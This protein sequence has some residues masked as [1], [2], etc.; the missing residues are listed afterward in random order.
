MSKRDI[1]V[2]AGP[3]ATGKSDL[4]VEVALSLD[5][6]VVSADSRQVYKELDL[7]SGKIAKAEMRG[8]P[9]HMLDVVSLKKN[10]SVYDYKKEAEKVIR[11]IYS[12]GK[13]PIITG[14]TGQYIDALVSDSTIPRVPEN[15]EL[16]N[17]L[18]KQTIQDLSAQLL[19]QNESLQTIVRSKNKRRIIRAL[20]IISTLGYYPKNNVSFSINDL[21]NLSGYYLDFEKE[22]L[23][24]RINDRLK[25]RLRE[26]MIEEV[27][28]IR[29][30]GISDE[31]LI[32][33]GLECRFITFYLRDEIALDEMKKQI[34]TKSWQYA[35]RQRTWFKKYR[36]IL[37]ER[38]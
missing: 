13:V 12:R 33:L 2:I 17:L 6:E 4:A 28:N 19:E 38:L 25:K 7:T 9:H 5:G 24:K 32:S 35:K 22:T 20:E 27:L 37:Q 16:R 18:E 14:G 1:I 3:T 31:K 29:I 11:D 21:Y 30:S 36:P 34:I 15:V 10:Y 23:M 26:G 8:V